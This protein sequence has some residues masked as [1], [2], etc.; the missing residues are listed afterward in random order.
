MNTHACTVIFSLCTSKRIKLNTS[1]AKNLNSVNCK[2]H[3]WLAHDNHFFRCTAASRLSALHFRN[4]F[5]ST[6]ASPEQLKKVKLSFQ[7]Q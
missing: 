1:S 2:Q 4:V 5:G 6:R 3:V 7:K